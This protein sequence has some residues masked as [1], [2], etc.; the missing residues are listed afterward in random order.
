MIFQVCFPYVPG[1]KYKDWLY[2]YN[3]CTSMTF[4]R[5]DPDPKTLCHD[6]GICQYA[7]VEKPREYHQVGVQTGV[8]CALNKEGQIELVYKTKDKTI[9]PI[10]STVQL[11]CE[12]T[13]QFP[14]FEPKDEDNYIFTIKTRCACPDQ[15]W[16]PVPEPTTPEPITPTSVVPSPMTVIP[17]RRHIDA[18][19][20]ALRCRCWRCCGGYQE[21]GK[22]VHSNEFGDTEKTY[23]FKN[24]PK[25]R[26]VEH[27]DK[28]T[29]PLQEE[30]IGEKT[31][32]V[33][34]DNVLSRVL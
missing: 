16:P 15:C 20:E 6:I 8:R 12:E 7:K 11:I 4:H 27:E 22:E 26:A 28:L 13:A 25:D 9:D 21:Q 19:K 10:Y 29:K 14:S 5:D 33:G 2:A 1:K 32:T 31:Q 17:T 3:P 23:L 24:K 30:D 18:V 34:K